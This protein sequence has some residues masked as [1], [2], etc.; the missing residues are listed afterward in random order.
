VKLVGREKVK[1]LPSRTRVKSS[2][3]SVW[4]ARGRVK[5]EASKAKV[6]RGCAWSGI[7]FSN[8]DEPKGA[9]VGGRRQ[10]QFD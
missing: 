6:K 4:A 1:V 7:P 9:L 10:A 5:A 8:F 3:V 2:M